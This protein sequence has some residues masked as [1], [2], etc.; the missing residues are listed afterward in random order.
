MALYVSTK[1]YPSWQSLA[2]YI[3]GGFLSGMNPPQIS[4]T[5]QVNQSRKSPVHQSKAKN[6]HRLKKCRAGHNLIPP[7]PPN[8]N[9]QTHKPITFQ[10][11]LVDGLHPKNRQLL[12]AVNMNFLS[13]T[14]HSWHGWNANSHT[15]SNFGKHHISFSST[16]H[17]PTSWKQ[18]TLHNHGLVLYCP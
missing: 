13:E 1:F 8:H 18:H 9:P 16:H 10:T 3:C 4:F 11:I 14:S 17:Q 15:W 6:H 12:I 2:I 7:R 5:L